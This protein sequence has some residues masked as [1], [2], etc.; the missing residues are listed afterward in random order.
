MPIPPAVANLDERAHIGARR[1]DL[2]PGAVLF[3]RHNGA[4]L[5]NSFI[6]T[7]LRQPAHASGVAA[8]TGPMA[9]A[10][11]H[12]FGMELALRGMPLPGIQQLLSRSDP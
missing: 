1:L 2:T 3:V 8:P 10:P 6:D 7:L 9:H 5:T 11:R 4:P 12:S